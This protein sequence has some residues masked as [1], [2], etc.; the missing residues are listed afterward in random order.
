MRSHL[1]MFK[2]PKPGSRDFYEVRSPEP[3]NY[4]CHRGRWIWPP[5]RCG[6]VTSPSSGDSTLVGLGR[7]MSTDSIL[8][9]EQTENSALIIFAESERPFDAKVQVERVGTLSRQQA[10]AE[11]IRQSGRW[12]GIIASVYDPLPEP[13][14]LPAQ[15]S[16]R[17]PANQTRHNCRVAIEIFVAAH[18]AD[19]IRI[20][21][22]RIK[23]SASATMG[24]DPR[25]A[26]RERALQ[27]QWIRELLG[28]H[29]AGMFVA[30]VE[31]QNHT[32]LA[33][34][35]IKRVEFA[36]P[37]IDSLD[38]SMN[39]DQAGARRNA[40][41]QLLQGIGPYRIDGTTGQNLG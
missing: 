5:G 6:R 34:Q 15:S 8:E 20:I 2:G 35:G 33:G 18:H 19:E 37:W 13:V 1:L 30:G 3:W 41:L 39:L 11:N 10:S 29:R 38:G 16:E 27:A 26:L 36:P 4:R 14:R 9:I 22:F 28:D 21:I 23:K 7:R 25:D 17:E 31:H 12:K 40:P 24:C 32:Q